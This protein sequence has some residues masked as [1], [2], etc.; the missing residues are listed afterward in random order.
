MA[1]YEVNI[2][3]G[4]QFSPDPVNVNLG[5]TVTWIWKD[6][7]MKHST[8]SDDGTS[9]ESDLQIE[10]FRYP[11]TFSSPQ[12]SAGSYAYHCSQHPA[13]MTGTIVVNAGS[14]AGGANC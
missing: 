11:V 7:G 5:D 4:K 2:G 3:P 14:Q 13:A 12:F 6:G 1:Q 10:P 8:T 9:W